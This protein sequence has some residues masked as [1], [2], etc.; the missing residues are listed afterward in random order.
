MEEPTED[1]PGKSK[2]QIKRELLAL[3]ALGREL[4]ALSRKD[5][6]QL[7]LSED[8]LEAITEARTLKMSAL[9][10]KI[11]HI[12]KLLRDE[13]FEA[14]RDALA[15]L[16]Q[17]HVEAVQAFHEVEQWR[18][19]LLAGNRELINELCQRYP[20]LDRQHLGQLVRNARKEASLQ[21][22]P[23]SARILFS[24]LKDFKEASES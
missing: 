17:P 11:K 10:R 15:R 5:L 23:K 7:P 21:K 20:D 8:L 9:A 6:A 16:R 22:A 12:G 3:Q 13:E 18:D 24:Y 2:S 1:I 14:I 4:V 19:T